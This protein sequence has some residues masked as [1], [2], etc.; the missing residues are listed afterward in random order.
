MDVSE[1]CVDNVQAAIQAAWIVDPP[2]AK[3]L[4]QRYGLYDRICLCCAEKPLAAVD[5]T[6]VLRDALGDLAFQLCLD[7]HYSES[8]KYLVRSLN[9]A[10]FA[11]TNPCGEVKL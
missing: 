4:A 9:V 3:E 7:C 11:S 1:P 8:R 5:P 2:F 6:R 10:T